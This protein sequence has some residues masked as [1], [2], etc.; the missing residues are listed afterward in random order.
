LYD[1][2]FDG[3]RSTIGLL[4]MAPALLRYILWLDTAA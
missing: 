1:D 4:V 2:L 3:I